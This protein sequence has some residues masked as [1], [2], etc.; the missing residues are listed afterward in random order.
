MIFVLQTCKERSDR[1]W[2]QPQ[3]CKTLL[4]NTNN[5]EFSASNAVRGEQWVGGGWESERGQD[6]SGG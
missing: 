3:E 4:I 6:I 1:Q 2:N 5:P